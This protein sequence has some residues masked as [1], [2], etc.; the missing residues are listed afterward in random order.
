[1]FARR[2]SRALIFAATVAACADRAHAD[3]RFDLRAKAVNG[4]PLSG[5]QTQH[6]IPNA[7]VGD[8]ITFDVFAVVRGTDANL[9][10]DRFV[11]AIGSLRSTQQVGSPNLLG[12]LLM[13][14]VRTQ[15]DPNTGE[16][17]GPNGFDEAGSTVG[18]RQDLDED[19][20]LD[21]GSNIDS[22]PSNYWAVRYNGPVQGAFAG[23]PNGVR[24]GFGT[25][26]VTSATPNSQT[27]L[28]FAGRDWWTGWNYWEDGVRYEGPSH[29]SILPES[30]LVTGAVPEPCSVA[31]LGLACMS[32]CRRQRSKVFGEQ[33]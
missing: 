4:A 10:N 1:M 25:F 18:V 28:H 12:D 6:S 15:Y 22:S 30:I 13:D 33:T 5:T 16:Q 24:I 8:I 23:P 19:G 14:I 11:Q 32:L 2:L 29:D 7:I 26:T 20:D 21:V 9:T 31:L 27:L 3:L 17:V